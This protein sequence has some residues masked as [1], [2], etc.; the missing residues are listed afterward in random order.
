MKR[1]GR[2]T[3]TTYRCYKCARL[4]TCLEIEA[5]MDASAAVSDGAEQTTPICPCGSGHISPTNVTPEEKKRFLN[6]WQLFRL[7]CGVHDDGT[8]VWELGFALL[9]DG[10][11]D[12][13]PSRFEATVARLFPRLGR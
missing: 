13:K 2:L 10:R 12:I 8:R 11:E 7:I 3:Y 5:R 6:L 9:R 4:L 1:T